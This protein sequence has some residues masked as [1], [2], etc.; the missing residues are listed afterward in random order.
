MD[1]TRQKLKG[2][3]GNP[4]LSH[5]QMRIG[6]KELLQHRPV[7]LLFSLHDLRCYLQTLPG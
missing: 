7:L 6:L 4:H 5:C 3:E 1:K 2:D